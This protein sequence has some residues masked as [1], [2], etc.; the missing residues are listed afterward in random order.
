VLGDVGRKLRQP[1]GGCSIAG[2]FARKVTIIGTQ[3][4]VQIGFD[5]VYSYFDRTCPESI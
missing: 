2:H 3:Q 1:P 4:S 5:L